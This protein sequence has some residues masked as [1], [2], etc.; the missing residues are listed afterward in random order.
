MDDARSNTRKVV[1]EE[2]E[3]QRRR[4]RTCRLSNPIQSEEGMIGKFP[5]LPMFCPRDASIP[6]DYSIPHFPFLM[7]TDSS[8]YAHNGLVVLAYPDK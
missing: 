3:E 2:K 7:L 8:S 1:M 5:L 6:R 4:K